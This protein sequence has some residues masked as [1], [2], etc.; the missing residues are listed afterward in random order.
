MGFDL[1]KCCNSSGYLLKYTISTKINESIFLPFS[2][3]GTSNCFTRPSTNP[4]THSLNQSLRYICIK[5]ELGVG[6][7]KIFGVLC[8]PQ[9][10]FYCFFINKFSKFFKIWSFM[11]GHFFFE[12][13]PKISKK[14]PEIFS[15]F[16]KS[17]KTT[18]AAK[19]WSFM[20]RKTRFFWS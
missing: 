18:S 10:T 16:S 8:P 15:T 6:T 7:P 19:I 4:T 11:S 20:S 1:K 17:K 9:G 5:D 3:V 12:K 14:F 2:K 13:F